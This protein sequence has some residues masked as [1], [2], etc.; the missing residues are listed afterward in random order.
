[1]DDEISTKMCRSCADKVVETYHFYIMYR[2]SDQKLRQLLKQEKGSQNSSLMEEGTE[3]VESI[4]VEE[5]IYESSPK[6]ECLVCAKRFKSERTLKRHQRDC[7]REILD[8]PSISDTDSRY[9]RSEADMYPTETSNLLPDLMQ[10]DEYLPS[11]ENEPY[12]QP[13]E[14][15]QNTSNHSG[16]SDNEAVRIQDDDSNASKNSSKTNQKAKQLELNNEWRCDKCSGV[17]LSK[18]ALRDHR[19]SHREPKKYTENPET[20]LFHCDECG[21]GFNTKEKVQMHVRRHGDIKCLC[22][23]CG[24]WLSCLGNL[25]KHYK[26]VHLNQKNLACPICDHRFTSSFR[27]RDHVNSHKGIRAYACEIC[28]TRFFN[29][30]AVKRH[31]DTVHR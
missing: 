3:Q 20:G 22:N 18:L 14:Q 21:K 29:Y 23:M 13:S 27:L 15:I 12:E 2:E 10:L 19:K 17:F 31:M 26:A 8:P 11:M 28:P 24:K 9:I 4:F 25:R 7:E 1:M 5:I 30:S 6:W 16:S